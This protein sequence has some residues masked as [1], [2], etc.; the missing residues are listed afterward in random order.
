MFRFDATALVDFIADETG[1]T[2][3]E[4]GIIAAGVAAAIAAVVFGL[5]SSV[6]TTLYDKIAGPSDCTIRRMRTCPARLF[7]STRVKPHDNGGPFDY[8]SAFSPLEISIVP[9]ASARRVRA[10]PGASGCCWFACG[11][12]PESH[13]ISK[14]ARKRPSGSENRSA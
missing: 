3:I 9:S 5:G 6:K 14:L 1:A 13:T 2:A 4:Y 10:E 8:R 7:R 12:Q 11:A